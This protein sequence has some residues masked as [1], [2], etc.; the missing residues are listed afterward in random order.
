V[1]KRKKV[2]KLR[3][4]TGKAPGNGQNGL[5]EAE[6]GAALLTTRREERE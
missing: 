4:L 1:K 6:R 2:T 3:K 5:G